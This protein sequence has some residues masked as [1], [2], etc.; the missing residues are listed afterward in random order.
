MESDPLLRRAMQHY[1]GTDPGDT[2]LRLIECALAAR[3][4]IS[5]KGTVSRGSLATSNA[6]TVERQAGELRQARRDL[7]VART[8]AMI[9][10]G[11]A[12]VG[13]LIV[14]LAVAGTAIREARAEAPAGPEVVLTI[15][16]GI[17][18]GRPAQILERRWP[19]PAFTVGNDERV[20]ERVKAGAAAIVAPIRASN[21]QIEVVYRCAIEV[22]P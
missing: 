22:T 11:L 4:P 8:R 9:W 15:I 7:D 18:D 21:P 14:G 1:D 5:M 13:W 2:D 3:M 20:C 17:S 19:V 10:K 12:I 6:A 16:A